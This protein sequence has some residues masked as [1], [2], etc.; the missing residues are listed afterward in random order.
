VKVIDAYQTF[1][2]SQV[3]SSPITVNFYNMIFYGPTASVPT[4]S[5]AVR[6]LGSRVFTTSISTFILNT[7]TVYNNFVAAMPNTLSITQ[8][9]DLDAFSAP[10]TS[11]Y[12]NS[13][14]NVNDAGGNATFYKVYTYT[15]AAAYST[16][17]R[18]QI[19]RTT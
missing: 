2:V 3:F 11:N 16:D 4:T 19:T 12:I 10:L 9:I 8:V 15:P 1:L 18:H 7:G 14:F 6:S 5:S 17:H 13:P